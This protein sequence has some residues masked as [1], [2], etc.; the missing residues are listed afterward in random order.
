MASLC[1][2]GNGPPGSLETVIMMDVI[3]MESEVNSVAVGIGDDMETEEKLLPEVDNMLDHDTDERKVEL[4]DPGC[5]L[6][7]SLCFEEMP[8][9]ITFP[10]VKSEPEEYS[11]DMDEKNLDVATED[12]A[13][14]PDKFTGP[15]DASTGD[16]LD[17]ESLSEGMS[18]SD[19]LGLQQLTA[20]QR[21]H[22][23][24]DSEDKPFKCEFCSL[25]YKLKSSL[26]S[27]L[28]LH[29]G[30]NPLRCEICGKYFSLSQSLKSHMRYAHKPSFKCDI[31][32]KKLPTPDSLKI[33]LEWHS[34]REGFQCSICGKGLANPGSLKRHLKGH[35]G[36]KP[37]KCSLCPR[38]F[39]SKDALEYHIHS[40]TGERPFRC[41]E[42]GCNFKNKQR[43]KR[44]K[45]AQK[46]ETTC[47]ICFE[48]FPTPDS[49][50]AHKEWHSVMQIFQ[51]SI[52]GKGLANSTTLKKHFKTHTG[53][54]PFKCNLCPRN[55]TKKDSLEN[56]I[57]SHTGERPFRCED[58]GCNFKNK[59]CVRRHKCKQ[60]PQTT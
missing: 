33:H 43:V 10:V 59:P 16:V 36:Y 17:N 39:T 24:L 35:E 22:N 13:I 56:H 14:L 41:E 30:D 50:K 37:Y 1:E 5:G 58:C 9:P 6:A 40:H 8:V 42:C 28:R 25:G 2:G 48:N 47:D 52:C 32:F 26:K 15:C 18:Q 12:N 4:V 27:H 57:R 60:Q 45:C 20:S 7:S 31:C 19:D 55:F 51:C 34:T 3:K 38:E 53:E 46:P 49:L 44:H 11:W 54:K 23:L 29:T 21:N